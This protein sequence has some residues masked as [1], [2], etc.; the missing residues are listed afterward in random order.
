M[1]FAGILAVAAVALEGV[2][3]HYI[4]QQVKAGSGSY[5]AIWQNIRAHTNMNSPV[6]SLT[7]NDLRCNVGAKAGSTL[8]VK[9]GETVSFK[10][11]TVRGTPV[12]MSLSVPI[13]FCCPSLF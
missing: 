1:K 2:S 10:L 11:D 8:S 13:V 12:M 5:G 7:S 9:A 3:A 4:F 6:T